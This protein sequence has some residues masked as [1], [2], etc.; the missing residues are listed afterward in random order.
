MR[1]GL[2]LPLSLIFLFI[3]FTR[4][5]LYEG[6]LKS[7]SVGNGYNNV[8]VTFISKRQQ[9]AKST[10]EEVI[11]T[12]AARTKVITRQQQPLPGYFVK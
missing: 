5:Q 4:S 12:S 10:M 11:R 7:Y 6:E 8:G 9:P 3:N 1:N 2:L